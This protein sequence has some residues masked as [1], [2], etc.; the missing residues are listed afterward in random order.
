M[1]F[2]LYSDA[3]KRRD[4]I[5]SKINSNKESIFKDA[6]KRWVTYEP[7]VTESRL[8][9]IDSSFNYRRYKGFYLYAIAGV[10]I[11][12]KGDLIVNPIVKLD[13]E[14]LMY[15]K[16]RGYISPRN[17]LLIRCM[18]IEYELAKR[19]A[20]EVD[21]IDFLLID[22]SIIAR[23]YDQRFKQYYYDDIKG[24]S[25]YYKDLL[26]SDNIIFV[27]KNSES[28][29]ILNGSLADIY[30]FS[31]VTSKPG[32]AYEYQRINDEDITVAY[33]RLRSCTPIIKVEIPSKR[34][35]KDI[36]E[37]IDMLALESVSGYPY[38]L[39]LAHERCKISDDDM[40]RIED[41]IGL[42]IE[43]GDREVLDE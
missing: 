6:E 37:I 12:S 29:S 14:K 17:I 15:D 9:G 26:R 31:K 5:V 41:M 40:S 13:V 35:E 23:F 8:A 18:K 16:S 4:S 38:V 24:L 3:L 11:T 30:Y 7:R 10:S 39:R 20:K 2:E 22:G 1:L 32:Y 27:A 43:E 36:R 42:S 21:D 34:D 33:V 25:E 28:N 19:S